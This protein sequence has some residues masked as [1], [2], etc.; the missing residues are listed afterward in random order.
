M[1]V[2]E[3]APVCFDPIDMQW[4]DDIADT[5]A[6]IVGDDNRAFGDEVAVMYI[7]PTRYMRK[8]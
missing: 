2:V 4:K 6:P 5:H 1:W 8:P 7:V 3:V